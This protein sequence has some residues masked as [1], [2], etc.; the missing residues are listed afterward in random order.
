L[1][2]HLGAAKAENWARGIVANMARKPQGGDSDQLRA[3]AAGVGDIAVTNHYYYARLLVSKKARDRA[4]AAKLKPFWPNQSD[5][6]VH[7]NI[8]GAGVAKYAPNEAN[9]VKLLE[10]LIGEEAQQIYA[11]VGHELPV[12]QGI[13]L[14]ETV[15]GLGKYKQDQIPLEILGRNNAAAVRIFDKV[16]WR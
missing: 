7:V 2:H 1:V 10:Y 15:A 6:G 5:R 8:S 14:S 16:G 13:A 12:R 4:V 11:E 9:A 3:V